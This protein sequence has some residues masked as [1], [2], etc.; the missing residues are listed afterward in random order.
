MAGENALPPGGRPVGDPPW[1]PWSPAEVRDRLRA[2]TVPWYVAAGWAL[3]LFRGEQTREHEDTE[4]GVPDTAE[5]FRQVR[6][7]PAG[8]EFEPAG[9]GH[10][11]P[12]RAAALAA[13][14]QTW[15]SE[16]APTRPDER[17]GRIY[18]LDVFREPYRDGRW[19]CRHDETIVLPYDQVIR[20]NGDDIPYL[21]PELALLFKAK[22]TRPKDQADFDDVLPL[23]A[24][25]QRSWLAGA[26]RRIHPGHK[27]LD[28]L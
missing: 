16:P 4:V 13:T 20:R 7:A 18:R 19:V 11:W 28:R 3:D 5:A 26:L 27:W 15:V 21:A 22:A 6:S 1:A 17:S 23:L 8:F 14:H 2:V 24:P 12:L 25:A 9:S 10:L